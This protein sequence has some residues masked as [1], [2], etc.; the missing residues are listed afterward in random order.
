MSYPLATARAQ[1][2]V[3]LNSS[4]GHTGSSEHGKAGGRHRTED[5][6]GQPLSRFTRFISGLTAPAGSD[7]QHFGGRDSL[8]IRQIG[9]RHQRPPQRDREEDPEHPAAH[10]DERRGPERKARPPAD[11][12]QTR[13]H[14]DDG[15]E[16]ARGRRNGL[17]DVVFE[18]R[19]VA[20]ETQERHRDDRRRDRGG[21]CEAD[22]ETE[23]DVRRGED[24][25]DQDA[26]HQTPDG[27]FLWTHVAD[28]ICVGAKPE[29]ESALLRVLE[30]R[31][32]QLSPKISDTW[33]IS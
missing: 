26:E 28:L 5:H 32:F 31:K 23:I 9:C 1:G 19:G 30:R 16:R 33:V 10:A 4:S 17:D 2:D 8:G 14:E 21:E 18:N 20:N 11:D 27:Q 24:R 22:F 3:A 13:Q 25:G 12:D 15:G 6:R 7:L 29:R